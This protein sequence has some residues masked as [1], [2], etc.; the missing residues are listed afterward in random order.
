MKLLNLIETKKIAGAIV[1][2]NIENGE[3]IVSLSEKSDHIKLGP[4]YGFMDHGLD[5]RGDGNAFYS[6]RHLVLSK[7]PQMIYTTYNYFMMSMSNCPGKDCM[8]RYKISN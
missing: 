4:G 2:L 6:V 8:F 3:I 7:T 1:T 5:L